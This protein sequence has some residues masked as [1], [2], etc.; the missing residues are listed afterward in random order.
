VIL[1]IVCLAG[2]LFWLSDTDRGR[3][4]ERG[5]SPDASAAIKDGKTRSTQISLGRLEAGHHFV[6]WED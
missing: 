3:R 5:L 1:A 2:L 4:A 6:D